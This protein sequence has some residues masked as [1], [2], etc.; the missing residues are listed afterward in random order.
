MAKV[1]AITNQKG[2]VGKTTTAINL[3]TCI[4][5][6]KKRVLLIDIDPQG[7][8]SSGIGLDRLK[9]K[10]CVYDVLINQVPINEVIM[11]T[12]IKNLDV[13]PSTI[14]LAGA[15]IELVNYIS[16]ENKLKHAIRPIKD[17]YE[18]IIIDCPPSLGLLT[19]NSLTAADSVIIPI[20]CEYYALEGISQLLNT[21]NLVRENL[22][23][24]LEIEGILFTM[25]DSRTNLSRDVVEEVKKY[26]RGKIFKSVIPRNVR[27]SEAPSYG[28]PVVVYDKKSKGAIAYKKLAKE[29]MLNG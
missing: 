1:F 18:Y 26:F 2:G 17:N 15:E 29:V 19:L 23:S 24:S 10:R 22:N 6:Y 7:N 20:Q 27:V 9:I 8:T 3:S 21:I 5:L 14:Q 4:S 11:Q 16:R 28:K 13:L 25:Y 12:Q